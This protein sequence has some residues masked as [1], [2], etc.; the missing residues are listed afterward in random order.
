MNNP[1]YSRLTKAILATTV[2]VTL[3]QVAN[4][5]ADVDIDDDGL[6]EISTLQ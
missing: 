2:A 3:G 5:A 1:R 6:I 4:A